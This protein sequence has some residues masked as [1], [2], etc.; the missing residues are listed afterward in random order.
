MTDLIYYLV[1][2]QVFMS[3]IKHLKISVNC[4]LRSPKSE[5][6]SLVTFQFSSF[7]FLLD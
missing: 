3:L 2:M 6:E 4:L 5:H 7:S 1:G